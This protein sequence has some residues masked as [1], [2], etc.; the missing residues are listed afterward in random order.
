M[1][2]QL[3]FMRFIIAGNTFS[4][5]NCI[6]CNKGLHLKVNTTLFSQT[7]V[8]RPYTTRHVFGFSDRW[9]LIDA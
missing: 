4:G 7:F 9:L 2:L 6:K 5:K 3:N 1:K 8:K